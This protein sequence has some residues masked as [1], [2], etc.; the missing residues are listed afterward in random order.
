MSFENRAALDT[1]DVF[2][3]VIFGDQP[4]VFVFAG[5]NL[6]HGSYLGAV[7]FYQRSLVLPKMIARKLWCS[8]S[9]RKTMQELKRGGRNKCDAARIVAWRTGPRVFSVARRLMLE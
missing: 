8:G 9:L 4:R 5:G 3:F 6:G 1:L 2:G 7:S